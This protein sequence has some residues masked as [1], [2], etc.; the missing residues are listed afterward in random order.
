MRFK[1]SATYIF[2]LII[3]STLVSL[4]D[5]SLPDCL[6]LLKNLPDISYICVMY[7]SIYIIIII[8]YNIGEKVTKF[9]SFME[10]KSYFQ[11]CALEK[12]P[13]YCQVK[14]VSKLLDLFLCLH[15]LSLQSSLG[16]YFP[17]S[18]LHLV[19][20]EWCPLWGLLGPWLFSSSLLFYAS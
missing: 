8:K 13:L 9:L 6:Y 15:L 12:S 1:S 19:Y 4:I 3:L 2:S 20:L 11:I 7:I 14:T 16:E 10:G 17:F 18:S 5:F